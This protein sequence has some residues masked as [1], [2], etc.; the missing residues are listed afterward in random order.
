MIKKSL[1]HLL[2]LGLAFFLG[3]IATTFGW[4]MFLILTKQLPVSKQGELFVVEEYRPADI[5]IDVSQVVGEVKPL[6][7]GYAQGGEEMYTNMLA[8]TENL[9]K[10]TH[11]TYIRLDHIFDDDYYGVVSG[12]SG[13][14]NLNWTKLDQAVDSI[15]ATGAKPF[16]AL[17]YMP[18]ALAASKIDQP[19]NWNDWQYLVK[20][21]IK[22][23]SGD[24]KISN[25]YYEVWNEPDLESFGAWKYHGGKNYLTLYATAARA[26]QQAR[27][28][29]VEPFKF[30]GPA[31]TALYQNWVLALT[32][33]TKEQNLP[34]DFISWHRYAYSPSQFEEDM[35]ELE[36]WLGSDHQYEFV[37][38]EWGPD[39][40]KT[41]IYSGR[42][43]AAHAVAVSRQ[44]LEKLNLAL[45]FEV[46][47]G[48]EQA[49]FGWG[50]LTYGIRPKPRYYALTYLAD[51]VGPRFA[52]SGEGSNV[53]AWAVGNDGKYKVIVS[54]FNVS[55]SQTEEFPIEFTNIEPGQYQ[56]SWETLSGKSD[57]RVLTIDKQ[58]LPVREYFTMADNDVLKVRLVLLEPY[59]KQENIV[60]TTANTPTQSNSAG[61]IHSG[62]KRVILEN[63]QE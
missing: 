35:Q 39:P 21:T 63:N 38:S 59:Q 34:L 56:L 61:S 27:D 22:H 11:P 57:S 4:V 36:T 25:V 10:Q 45:A 24:K 26:A 32:E 40:G 52:L 13:N 47:D 23:Y 55:G 44:L 20:Q 31:T 5:V 30:G 17:T 60:D 28:E 14:L 49:D 18:K 37:I 7:S 29:R 6:W 16:L 33:L 43:A 8:G 46:K 51:M 48:P 9:L 41:A 3:I 19:Y 2:F 15:L 53:T 54:N 58:G 1:S 12:S 50:V 62:F 42:Y